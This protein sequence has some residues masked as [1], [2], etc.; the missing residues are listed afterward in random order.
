MIAAAQPV[1]EGRMRTHLFDCPV[2]SLTI[3]EAVARVNAF[4]M[5][6]GFHN[7]VAIN[8]NKL[9]LAERDPAL[10]H[11]LQEAELAIPEYAAVWACRILGT[12]VRGHVGGVMLVKALLP[13]L[14]RE[15]VPAYFLG[16]KASVLQL[17]LQRLRAEHPRLPIAGMRSGYFDPTQ[18]EQIVAEINRSGAA[19]LFVAMGSPRQELW[20]NRH[21]CSLAVRVALGVG[22]TFDVLAGLKKDTPQW[23][24]HGGEWIYRLSQDPRNLWKRYLTTN[25]WFVYRVVRECA[26]R[27]LASR[28]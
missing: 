3:R 20:V 10:K 7:V 1:A 2:D 28:R 15:Q 18:E 11:V 13:W 24:R 12:P 4:L 6:G 21:R 27:A 19:I 8:A 23:L 5:Q 16:A 9:W 26:L 14:E 17:M 25:P 22:G